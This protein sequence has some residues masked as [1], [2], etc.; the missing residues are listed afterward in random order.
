M[1]V[2]AKKSERRGLILVKAEGNAKKGDSDELA[3]EWSKLLRDAAYAGK[4]CVPPQLVLV[5]FR[6]NFLLA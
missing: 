2:L 5:E 3:R 6:P 4:F 1:H